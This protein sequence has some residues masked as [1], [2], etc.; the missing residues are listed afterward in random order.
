MGDIVVFASGNGSNFQSIAEAL[1]AT[2]HKI[3]CLICD[4]KKAYALKR[5]ESLSIPSHYISYKNKKRE[6]AE[7]EILDVLEKYRI[8][9]IV[10]AGFM[11]IF[12]K[13]IVDR[14]SSRI[15][16]IHPSLLPKYPG[17]NAIEKSYKSGDSKLG[18]SIHYVDRGMDT[19]RIITQK[20]FVKNNDESIEEIEKR[21][22]CLEHKYYPETIIKLLDSTGKK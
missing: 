7:K 16:N 1:R 19:G 2:D 4:R 21:I 9:L 10:L 13:K 8:D 15:I 5:A 12:T 3:S 20:S 11:R 6:N 22:H 18:I 17:M 14:Y